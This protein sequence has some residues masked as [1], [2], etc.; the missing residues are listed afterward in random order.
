MSLPFE[1]FVAL[2]YLKTK[3]RGLFSWVTTGIGVAGVTIGVA[4]LLTTLSV[5]NGFQSDIRKKIVGAQAHA[6]IYARMD[7]EKKRALERELDASP[8]VAARSS[9]AVGQAIITFEDR[10]TGVVVKGIDP[11][12]EFKVNELARS[13]TAGSWTGLARSSAKDADGIVLGEE[14]AHSLGA[15]VGETVVL[16]SPTSVPTPL[17][18]IPTMRKFRVAGLLHTGYYEYDS[19][20]AYVSLEAAAAFFKTPGGLSGMQVRLKDINRAERFSRELQARLGFG[21]TVRSFSDLNR[22]LFAALKLEKYVMFLILALIILVASLN[23]ASNLILL[24]ADKLRDIGLLRA[25]GAGP[26]AVR[27][28]FL[29]VGLLI[30]SIGVFL[31]LALGLVLCAVIARYPI[32]ELPADIY[33]LSRVPV[34]IDPVDVVAVCVCG[35]VLALLATLYPAWRASRVDPIEAIHYG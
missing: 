33:Y 19:G 14:L 17:G 4:A 34:H 31:G 32:V 30:G 5:M 8:E 25:M 1:L 2:R 6:V 7:E 3:R 21:F 24:G 11:A 18:L 23:I 16:V 27:R 15:Y 26:R 12:R 28:V 10:S 9:F 20:T 22:T 29:W 13:L 35:F